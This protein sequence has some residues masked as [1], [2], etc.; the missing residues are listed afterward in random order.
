MSNPLPTDT[1]LVAALNGIR[2]LISS[3]NGPAVMVVAESISE[4]IMHRIR[5]LMRHD[6]LG[7]DMNGMIW[8]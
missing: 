3:P 6:G 1:L 8:T 5:T 4:Y 7:L 2:R